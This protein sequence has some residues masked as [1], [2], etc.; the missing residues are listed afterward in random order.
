[1]ITKRLLKRIIL[2]EIDTGI[3]FWKIQ[4]ANYIPKGT[5]AGYI[6]KK[7]GYRIIGIGG[8]EYK[9]NRLAFLYM[10]GI[11]PKEV[12]H[13]NRIRHDDRWINLQ[14]SSRCHNMQNQSLSSANKT[15]YTGVHWYKRVQKYIAYI[16]FKRKR[17]H[18]GYFKNL[19]QAVRARQRAK[20]I[21]N[22]D[23]GGN[24]I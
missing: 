15:G 5:R 7:T 4:P 18:L 12:D 11:M 22:K 2:Y 23:F 8:K 3:F 19:S 1:M 10:T 6:N 24:F 20:L 13:K 17:Y 14:A 21:I 16:E 9:A